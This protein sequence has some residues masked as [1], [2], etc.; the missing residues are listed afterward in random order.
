MCVSVGLYN[1]C[2]YVYMY[3]CMYVC[4]CMYAGV[5]MHVCVCMCVCMYVCIGIIGIYALTMVHSQA[6]GGS[7]G[8]RG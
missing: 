6:E 5:C 8:G 7:E 3:V 1:V 2:M 4:V